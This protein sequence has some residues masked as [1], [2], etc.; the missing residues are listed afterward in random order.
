MFRYKCSALISHPNFICLH[1]LLVKRYQGRAS[2]PLL[3]IKLHLNQHRF[4]VNHD[5]QQPKTTLT[6]E[7]RHALTNFCET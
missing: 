3:L 6:W 4:K 2:P 5:Y 1:S 7:H